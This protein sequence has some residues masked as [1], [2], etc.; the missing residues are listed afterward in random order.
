MI[1]VVAGVVSAAVC[2]VVLGTVARVLMRLVTVV[3]GGAAEFSWAGTLGIVSMFALAMLPGAVGA[4]FVAGPH[5]WWLLALGAV[6]LCLPAVGIATEE[7]GPTSSFSTGQ[8]VGVIALG[9]AI[10]AVIA[11]MPLVTARL[12]DRL[13]SR[14]PVVTAA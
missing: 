5:R 4:A 12:V 14:S 7:L 6:L 1:R 3:A 2:A 11:A 8:W 10:F 13:L 9:A